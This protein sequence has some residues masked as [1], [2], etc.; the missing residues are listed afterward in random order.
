MH[1]ILLG[2]SLFCFLLS[3]LAQHKVKKVITT[4][5]QNPITNGMSGAKVASIILKEN[6]VLNVPVKST[7]GQLTDNYN[8]LTREV[9]LSTAIFQ[10]KSI[11]AVAVAAHEV[12]HAL[13]HHNKYSFLVLRTG[14]Y[15]LLSFTSK[16]FPILLVISLV[17]NLTGLFQ[18]AI[19]FYAVSVVF[20]IITLPVEFDASK[21]ALVQLKKLNLVTDA[22]LPQVK[23]VLNAAAMTYIAAA[24]ISIVELLRFIMYFKSE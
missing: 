2:V 3:V 22:E 13:Q 20:A 23:K 4:N 5:H 12:G 6:N 9:S 11:S 10:N 14:L 8:P 1:T 18:L 16:S 15:P 21:R 17:L 19:A 24:L 7:P